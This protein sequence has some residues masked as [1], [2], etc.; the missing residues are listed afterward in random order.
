MASF[1]VSL[2]WMGLTTGFA[3]ACVALYGR[4]RTLP[5]LLTGPTVCRLDGANGCQILFRTRNAALLGAPNALLGIACYF[6]IAIGIVRR[7]STILLFAGAG[8]ALAMSVYLAYI[9]VRD[10]LECRV[11]WTGH[12]ANV[13]LWI[14]LAIALVRGGGGSP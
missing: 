1:S 6:A 10:H 7:W 13:L 5:A 12:A 2:V 3:A 11:C 14:G 9:L 4:Y 8:A